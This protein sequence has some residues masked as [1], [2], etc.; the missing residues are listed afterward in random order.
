MTAR[1]ITCLIVVA[2]AG[3]AEPAVIEAT[4]ESGSSSTTTGAPAPEREPASSD[5]GTTEAPSTFLGN[6]DLGELHQCD[7]FAQD[8]P[9]G[10]KCNAYASM[11][12]TWDAA[13]C[14]PV[15]E[16]P[17][18]VGEP[19]SVEG[20][21]AS[22]I[23]TCEVG[24]MCWNVNLETNEGECIAY[25]TGDAS[26]PLCDDPD[27]RCGGLRSF[28]QCIEQC[29]PIEQDCEKPGYGCYWGS[30]SFHCMPNAAP[31]SMYAD[32]CEFL[33]VCPPGTF[34][35][36]PEH[37]LDCP[38]GASGCC[39]PFCRLGSNDCAPNTTS[40][41]ACMPWFEEGH[42]G[43]AWFTRTS[44]GLHAVIH[45]ETMTARE[46][47]CLIV[48]ALASLCRMPA[49]AG[50]DD[51]SA[52]RPETPEPTRQTPEPPEDP[53]PTADACT[54][55]CADLDTD[56]GLATCQS[57]RCKDAFDGW[58]PPPETLQCEHGE[59]IVTYHAELS[60]DGFV[61]EPSPPSALGCA[62]PS[63]LTRS[64]RQGSRLGHARHEDVSFYWICRD[65]YLDLDGTVMY[66]DMAA[67]GHN[68]RTGATCFWD[69]TDD[70]THDADTPSFDLET[71]TPQE[72]ARFA[73]RF[74][75]NDGSGCVECH[76]HDPFLYT[77]HLRSVTWDSIAADKGPYHLVGLEA[78]RAVE[79]MHL[80]SE[81]AAPCTSC[82]RLG[83]RQTCDFFAPDS[84]GV[85]AAGYEPEMYAAAEPGSPHWALA[86]W[87]PV[88]PEVEDFDDWEAA[89]AEARD[90]I[91][92]C[93]QA[94]GVDTGDCRWEPVE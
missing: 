90:H 70:V 34:C 1:E 10:Y 78:P 76:D 64:C 43:P 22:G 80:V 23:D 92:E 65:P 4:P 53:E 16:D 32:A 52:E 6:P 15:V 91:V 18:E 31:E 37:A 67:I 83:S 40:A 61:L 54:E 3:C 68:T 28:P 24:A 42:G 73:Q 88:S 46:I 19:C 93:C 35:A 2:L 44:T 89:Y 60:D 72:Q 17:D 77:P 84:F 20:N 49:P 38:A 47:T 8:C 25:C 71:S 63:L 74:P 33:N 56:L 21:G 7:T 58:L 94:P 5:D 86:Y 85:K 48:V 69:D 81:A 57:C 62:N 55:A 41:L 87:M 14:F 36:N 45:S 12:G 50:C 27:T 59:A 75:Y 30:H 9:A 13:K 82:H 26:N 66:R 29:C 51:R 39:Q 79:V 11:G